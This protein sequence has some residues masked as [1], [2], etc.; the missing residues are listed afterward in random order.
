TRLG[1][2]MAPLVWQVGEVKI[3]QIVEIEAGNIMQQVIP[4]ATPE[5]LAAIPWLQPDYADESGNLKA[6]V[7]S[8]VVET[9]TKRIL[10]D[11]CVGNAKRRT[12]IPEWNNLQ[13]DY[14]AKVM[15]QGFKLREIDVVLCTHLHCDH[16]GWNIMHAGPKSVPT[17]PSA[18][19][20]FT[21]V[22]L[23]YWQE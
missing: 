12:D 21:D 22:E 8:F 13:T 2:S 19:Y 18:K 23:K 14:L 7:Q 6:L 10:V 20:M 17:F 15:I 5:N 3:T 1:S 16:V 9:P 4:Q 11:T